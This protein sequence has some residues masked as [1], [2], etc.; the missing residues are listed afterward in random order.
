VAVSVKLLE[1]YPPGLHTTQHVVSVL[2]RFDA[3]ALDMM[4]P[5][6]RMNELRSSSWTF[7][8]LEVRDSRSFSTMED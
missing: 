5:T 4:Y 7:K 3:A 1:T 8:G 6:F 2:L